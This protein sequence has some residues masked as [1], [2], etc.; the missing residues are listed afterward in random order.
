MLE[1]A[2][3]NVCSLTNTSVLCLLEQLVSGSLVAVIGD[4][5]ERL[6]NAF[7]KNAARAN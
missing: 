3:M 2:A 1:E 6:Q 5:E 7:S 4:V